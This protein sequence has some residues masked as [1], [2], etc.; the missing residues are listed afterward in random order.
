[1]KSCPTCNRTYPDDTLAFCLMD[2]SVLSAPYDQ[3]EPQRRPSPRGSSAPATEV[4]IAPTVAAV[5]KAPL[6]STI[7]APAPPAEQWRS[8]ESRALAPVSKT[9]APAVLRWALILRSL[10][11]LALLMLVFAW[12]H[13]SMFEFIYYIAAYALLGGGFAIVAGIAA[14]SHYK[15]GWFLLTDGLL[16]VLVGLVL[17]TRVSINLRL[18]IGLIGWT[19]VSGILQIVAAIRL[20]QYLAGTWG[21]VFGGV[22]SLAFGFALYIGL[23][24]FY[25]LTAAFALLSGVL[26]LAFGFRL[27]N[28]DTRKR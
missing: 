4:L 28:S 3:E 1:M 19:T 27:R 25:V 13:I 6:Q 20:R 8:D 24:S 23:K 2:G 10:V 15:R 22:A 18:L 9:K 16:E 5:E 11:L 26:L 12:P 21:L 14:Q 17:L 7:Q